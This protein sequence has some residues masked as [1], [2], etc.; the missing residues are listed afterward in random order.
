MRATV[1]VGVFPDV[2]DRSIA[3][4]GNRRF[5]DPKNQQVTDTD[6]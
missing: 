3:L 6:L 5:D 4:S 1:G 2:Y